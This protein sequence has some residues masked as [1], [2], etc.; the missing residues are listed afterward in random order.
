MLASIIIGALI[1]IA[2]LYGIRKMLKESTSGCCGGG[3][4]TTKVSTKQKN[5]KDFTHQTHFKIEDIHCQNCAIKIENLFNEDDHYYA[6]VNVSKREL[7]LYSKQDVDPQEIRK[8]V[9]KIGYHAKLI[10]SQQ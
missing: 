10:E 9:N 2:F 5:I 1:V 7:S 3:N 4:C 8:K 6:K